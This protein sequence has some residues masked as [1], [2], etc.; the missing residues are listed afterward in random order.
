MW[1]MNSS[2]PTFDLAMDRPAFVRLVLSEIQKLALLSLTPHR[3]GRFGTLPSVSFYQE[4]EGDY[5]LEVLVI[6]SDG[7]KDLFDL[8]LDVPYYPTFLTKILGN[9]VLTEKLPAGE[10]ISSIAE[11]QRS[12]H[13]VYQG[14]YELEI[15]S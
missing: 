9:K 10:C 6:H 15:A 11:R 5:R 3:V 2:N 7:E 1:T 14:G 12:H 13:N 8:R 4:Y